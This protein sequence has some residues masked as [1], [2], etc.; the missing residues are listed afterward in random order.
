MQRQD[1]QRLEEAMTN[2]ANS[3]GVVMDDLRRNPEIDQHWLAIGQT[4]LQQGFMAVQRA[5]VR[6][7]GF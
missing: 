3:L 6:P 4:H 5:I 2:L 1:E 7:E